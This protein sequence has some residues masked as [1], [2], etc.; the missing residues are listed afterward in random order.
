MMKPRFQCSLP[1]LGVLVFGLG[2]ASGD[3]TEWKAQAPAAAEQGTTSDVEEGEFSEEGGDSQKDIDTLLRENEEQI[4]KLDAE[5][6]SQ[7]T[8]EEASKILADLGL[9]TWTYDELIAEST[10]KQ[11]QALSVEEQGLLSRHF[12]GTAPE[13]KL[14]FAGRVVV[15]GDMLFDADP[16]LEALSDPE[17]TIEKGFGCLQSG[18]GNTGCGVTSTYLRE[19]GDG[20]PDTVDFFRPDVQRTTFMIVANNAP[21]FFFN[22]LVDVTSRIEDINPPGDC[23]GASAFTPIRQSAYDALDAFTKASA[24][25]MTVQYGLDPCPDA[26]GAPDPLTRACSSLP[27][28]QTVMIL[29]P[30]PNSGGVTQGRMAFGNSLRV[31]SRFFPSDTVP[32]RGS[33]LHELGHIMGRAHNVV[34]ASTHKIPGTSVDTTVAS[35]MDVSITA[36][37]ANSLSGDDA[38]VIKTL[39]SDNP[40][41]SN[42]ACAYNS[43]F[44]NF[45]FIAF[46]GC[47]ANS[48][49][50]GALTVCC[51]P[52]CGTCGG[53]GCSSRP[54]GTDACCTGRIQTNGV[55]CSGRL[56]GPC[57]MP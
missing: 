26:N 25:T 43:G 51:G 38:Q 57:V 17:R 20:S 6:R 18:T 42:D 30:G 15:I 36:N 55:S 24:F 47:P 35:V 37:R 31:N 1:A 50:N 33:L 13:E 28:G 14:G 46:E 41:R 34:N 27:S 11:T 29:P 39:Y 45:R 56:S 3:V 32:F 54:G 12:A 49:P 48:I 7:Y 19:D 22:A 53:D 44:R 5:W 52:L 8:P 21:T 23:L 40:N 9:R 4:A 2:C 16:L 10:R